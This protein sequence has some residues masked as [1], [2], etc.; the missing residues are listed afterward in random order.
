M[1]NYITKSCKKQFDYKT[2][3]LIQLILFVLASASTYSGKQWAG[4][5][6][7]PLCSLGITGS[8]RRNAIPETQGL[9]PRVSMRQRSFLSALCLSFRKLLRLP[10]LVNIK[11]G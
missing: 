2:Y 7:R 6:T 10:G 9:L 11:G 8:L 5:D 3:C 4:S 1:I